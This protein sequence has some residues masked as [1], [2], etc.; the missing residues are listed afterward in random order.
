MGPIDEYKELKLV[1]SFKVRVIEVV[2]GVAVFGLV[3]FCI[4]KVFTSVSLVYNRIIEFCDL[5]H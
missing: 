2:V 1:L 5:L 4:T 3:T